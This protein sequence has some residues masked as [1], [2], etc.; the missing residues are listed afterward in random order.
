MKRVLL[1]IIMSVLVCVVI[2]AQDRTVTGKVTD[3][4]GQGLPTVT[5]QI[6]G[7]TQGQQTDADGNYRI[8]VPENA[9]LVFRFL[10]YTEMEEVVGNRGNINVQMQPEVSELDEVVVTALGITRD[11]ASLGY[12]VVSIGAED[13]QSKPESD[14]A[15]ILRGKV[16]GVDIQQTSG[17]SG[18]GT[19][20]IIRGY[21]SISGS[22]QP[23]FVIDGVPFNSDTNQDRGF[24]TGGA[25]A[26]SRMM[27]LD[28]NNIAD[29]SVLKGLSATVLYGEQGKN[30][31]ILVTTK[32]GSASKSRNKMDISLTQSYFVNE[33][34]S[35]PNDQDLYGNGFYNL[36][37]AAFSNWGAPFNQPGKNGTS[38]STTDPNVAAIPHPYDRAV[39]NDALPEFIGAEHLYKPYDNLQNF[40]SKGSQTNTSLN[41]TSRLSDVG[42]INVSYGYIKDQ[43]YVTSN[44]FGKHNL[45]V[46][47]RTTLNNGLKIT[48]ALNFVTS[49]GNKPPSGISTSSNPA[50][51]SLFSNVLYTPRSNDLTGWPFELPTTKESIYYRGNNGIQNPY[52]TLKNAVETERLNRFFGNVGMSYELTDWLSA[53]Y[54]FGVDTYTQIQDYK[55]NSR[56]IQQPLGQFNTSNRLNTVVNHDFTLTANRNINSDLNL[57]ILLGFNAVRRTRSFSR[58]TSSNQFIFDLFTHQN[59]LVNTASSSRSEVNTLG[60]YG[61]ASLGYKDFLYLNVQARNDWTSTLEEAN[62]SVFYPSVSASFLPF[63]AFG[64]SSSTFNFLKVR[65]GFGT[66]AG[67][68]GA[69]QTRSVLNTNVNVFVDENGQVINTN[70]ISTFFGN[71]GLTAELHSELEVGIEGRFFK[72]KITL[73]VSLYDKTSSD[74]IINLTLDPS[75][76]FNRST[77]NAAEINNKGIEARITATIVQNNDWNLSLTGNFT[78]NVSIVNRIAD[79]VDQ[80]AIAGFGNLGNFAIP[81]EQY[82]VIQGAPILRDDNGNPIVTGQGLYQNDPNLGIIGDPNPNYNA[83]MIGDLSYKFLSLRVQFDYQNGGDLVSAT[84]YTLLGRGIAEATG[85]DRF[86]PVIARGVKSDGSPNDIQITSTDQ[87]WRNGGVFNAELRVYD[88]TH[89]RLREISLTVAFP[90]NW[91]AKTP[92]G[93]A[94]LTFS[95]QNLWF[96]A[97][98]FPEGMNFDPEVSSTGVGNGRGFEFMSG[99][100]ARR[101]GGTLNLTF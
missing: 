86:V 2:Q 64:V 38:V 65:V 66:S 47:G 13:I 33:A 71:P 26:S 101:Y 98:N 99:P 30:G 55:I 80:V 11:K 43:G 21:S 59:F 4:T 83:T 12:A 14:V 29:I 44:D 61:M 82:G 53:N 90:S 73:D 34:A 23:L 25:T 51:S 45:S 40:F 97:F 91:L 6:K 22:N 15:R 37:S 92:F 54:R 78:K 76:G 32:T 10:G 69:Y 24:T 48:T 56:G 62:R 79:G 17:L 5:V 95:G 49:I 7:T 100:S 42:S 84:A 19:N 18:S 8:S 36:A 88:A 41:I 72:N 74:L 50:G 68:P 67:Y 60:A 1:T 39:W 46:G 9:T 57:D 93:S 77:V 16:P 28:P 81:G 85:F 58:I 89:I 27:D 35:L 20:I 3:E 63:D 75:T 96:R 87:Y 52:W 70:S 94:S 31:V